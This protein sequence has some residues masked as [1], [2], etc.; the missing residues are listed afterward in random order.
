ML[1][2]ANP[3]WVGGGVG[4][5]VA[6]NGTCQATPH[7]LTYLKPLMPHLALTPL[8]PSLSLYFA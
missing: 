7:L 5:S 8:F 2:G 3:S 1:M 6:Q 4:E